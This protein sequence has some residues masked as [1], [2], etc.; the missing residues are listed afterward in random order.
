MSFPSSAQKGKSDGWATNRVRIYIWGREDSGETVETGP[1]PEKGKCRRSRKSWGVQ[2]K[3][4]ANDRG[5]RGEE[6]YFLLKPISPA[7][8]RDRP[9]KLKD[10]GGS[11]LASTARG[12]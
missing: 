4:L 6:D 11:L 10:C 3:E 1:A 9:G 12:G 2:K 8:G 7:L 5:G